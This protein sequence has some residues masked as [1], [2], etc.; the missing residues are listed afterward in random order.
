MKQVSTSI[1]DGYHVQSK[2]VNH[3]LEA[4]EPIS[5][6]GTDLAPNPSEMLLAALASCKAITCKMYA[7]R[8]KWKIDDIRITLTIRDEAP[9]VIEQSIEFI[10]DLDDD[11]KK[12]LFEISGRCPVAKMIDPAIEIKSV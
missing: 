5:V 9:R 2:T 12:R 8:K 4:D 1:L 10:G 11:Q 3:I 6:G 7:S